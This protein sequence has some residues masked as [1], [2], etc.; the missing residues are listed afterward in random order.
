MKSGFIQSFQVALIPVVP[1][2]STVL[3]FLAHTLL[4]YRLDAASVRFQTSIN[5][6][7]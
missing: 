3:L 2:A 1:V 5:K 4:G 6:L 7:F